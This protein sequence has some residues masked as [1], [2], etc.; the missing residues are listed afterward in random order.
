MD[1]TLRK[2]FF[3][4][5]ITK[6]YK[7]YYKIIEKISNNR[8][9]HQ[10]LDVADI[11]SLI[12]LNIEKRLNKIP[13]HFFLDTD[14]FR[15]LFIQTVQTQLT[16]GNSDITIFKKKLNNLNS[17]F[18]DIEDEIDLINTP[19]RIN[20]E[21][22]FIPIEEVEDDFEDKFN[23]LTETYPNIYKFSNN[24]EDAMFQL[25]IE[26]LNY[27]EVKFNK[28]TQIPITTSAKLLKTFKDK[29]S[30]IY[31]N[32]NFIKDKESLKK[33]STLHPDFRTK[34]IQSIN[35]I[36]NKY[37]YIKVIQ[38]FVSIREQFILNKENNVNGLTLNNYGLSTTIIKYEDNEQIEFNFNDIKIFKQNGLILNE[39][40]VISIEIDLSVVKNKF[41]NKDFLKNSQ[42]IN[43]K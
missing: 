32:L 30:F 16:W 13:E 42:F 29:I 28:I 4:S 19:Q 35:K 27:S 7:D 25:I 2:Q 31:E 41:T 15:S 40:G 37:I 3:N 36:E 9:Q 23:F 5:S 10:D 6:N 20:G 12:Y 18:N 38:E 39:N 24:I 43:L 26:N 1:I 8:K 34:L 33:L 11:F 22:T 17:I 14:I 21:K